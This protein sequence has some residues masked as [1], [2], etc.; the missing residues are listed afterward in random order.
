MNIILIICAVI[1]G[2]MTIG[3]LFSDFQNRTF[4]TPTPLWMLAWL[5]AATSL[6][7]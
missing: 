2:G 5:F 6:F 1:A 3:S 4:S 7:L